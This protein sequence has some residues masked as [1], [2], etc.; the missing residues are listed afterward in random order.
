MTTLELRPV[1]PSDLPIFFDQQLDPEANQMAA[2]TA[3]D[4]TD[5][6][7]FQARWD[8]VLADES[9]LA[10]AV[11]VDGEVVGSVGSFFRDA[12]REVTYWIGREH[13]G[14]GLATRALTALLELDKT[15]PIYA[16][17]ACDNVASLR[18]LQKCGFQII[19]RDRGFAEA[20]GCEIDEHVLRLDATPA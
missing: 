9:C 6:E 19:D 3:K 4:P 14:K 11:V 5:R 10:R 17:V 13:W 15:R 16:R 18:V 7:A 8:R 20:R 1:L 2:F 12:D